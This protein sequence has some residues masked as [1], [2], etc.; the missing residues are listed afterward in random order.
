MQPGR[1][2]EDRIV[3]TGVGL[4]APIGNRLDEFRANLLSGKSGVERFETRYMGEV[5]AGVCRFVRACHGSEIHD[6]F[7]ATD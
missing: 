4:T 6:R 2:D 3:I 5:L 7:K 1:H